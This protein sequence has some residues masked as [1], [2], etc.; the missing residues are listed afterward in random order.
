M[1]KLPFNLIIFPLI[2][3]QVANQEQTKFLNICVLAWTTHNIMEETGNQMITVFIFFSAEKLRRG[4][5]SNVD[6][7]LPRLLLQVGPQGL[8]VHDQQLGRVQHRQMRVA[9][10]QNGISMCRRTK[11]GRKGAKRSTKFS[12]VPEECASV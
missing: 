3:P 2:K 8:Q 5:R 4:R 12:E 6:R 1:V 7:R 11:T 9:P 10:P